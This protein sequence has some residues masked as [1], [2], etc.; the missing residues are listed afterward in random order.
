MHQ[1]IAIKKVTNLGT[2]NLST[3]K[4]TNLGTMRWSYKNND[5]EFQKNL[6]SHINET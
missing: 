2:M 4:K 6:I 5:N 1:Q 3:K